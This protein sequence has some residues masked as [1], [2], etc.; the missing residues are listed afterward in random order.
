[1]SKSLE[2][3]Q[4]YWGH[5]NFRPLQQEIIDSAVYGHDTL[6]LL[7][8]GAG[9]SICFQVPA[10]LREGVCLVISPLIALMQDQVANLRKKGIKAESIVSGMSERDIDI[11][12]DNV[13]FGEVKFLYTSPERLRNRLFLE[14]FKLM[15]V[16]LIAVDEAHCISQWGFDFRPSY[17]QIAD[18]REIH[19]EVPL[20]ALTATA[21]QQ[22]KNDITEKLKLKNVHFFEGDFSRANLAYKVVDSEY[23]EKDLIDYVLKHQNQSGIVY[24]QTRKSTKNIAK[25]LIAQR[26]KASFYHGGL[27]KEER[28]QKQINW[29]QN[30]IQV[31]VATNAFGMGIDKPDV[32]FVLHYEFPDSLEAYFQEAG[33]AGRDGKAAE[34]LVFLEQGDLELLENKVKERFPSLEKIKSCYKALCNF[35]SIA[36][37]SGQDESYP[38]DLNLFVRTFNLDLLETYHCLQILELNQT[39]AFS[40]DAL[41]MTRVKFSIST[42]SLYNFQLQHENLDPLITLISRLYYGV[43]DQFVEIDEAKICKRLV[44]SEVELTKQ[45]QFLESHGVMEISWRSKLP[46]LTFLVPR[47]LDEHFSISAAVFA[48]RKKIALEKLGAVKTYL[49]EINCRAVMLSGYFGQKTMPC[50]IC[51][52]CKYNENDFVDENRLRLK[53]HLLLQ[54]CALSFEELCQNLLRYD[55]QLI[56]KIINRLLDEKIIAMNDQQLLYWKSENKKSHS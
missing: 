8:T 25:L 7:S 48:N 35:L 43:F 3:L 9:K 34:A 4:K 37:G 33:R 14:R 11:V 22:V 44:C 17:L 24:C 32:R 5:A 51:D 27:S 26:V 49:S 47:Q 52:V 23:K 38:F 15:K 53:I 16:G 36:Y 50:G 20:I 39:L 1:L 6:A 56:G 19:S 30:R 18:I 40:A 2:I 45:L 13:R 12:L 54:N 55:R 29:I 21:T 31:I 42:I 46:Q 28:A 10:L 41:K